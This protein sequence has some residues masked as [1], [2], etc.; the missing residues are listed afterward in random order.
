MCIKILC[1]VCKVLISAELVRKTLKIKLIQ[2]NSDIS[3]SYMYYHSNNVL[4]FTSLNMKRKGVPDFRPIVSQ[5]FFTIT[6]LIDFGN[7]EI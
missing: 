4:T 5:T 2:L 3:Y 1:V 7:T 6:N